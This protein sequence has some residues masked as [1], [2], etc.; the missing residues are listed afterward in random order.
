M[1]RFIGYPYYGK[2][3]ETEFDVANFT[4]LYFWPIDVLIRQGSR[5]GRL[6]RGLISEFRCGPRIPGV[7]PSYVDSMRATGGKCRGSM[8][9]PRIR[10]PNPGIF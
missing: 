10:T 2:C 1:V 8:R 5:V 6:G 3:Y 9:Q 7:G 4:L